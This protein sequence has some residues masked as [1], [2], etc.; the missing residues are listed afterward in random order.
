[1]KVVINNKYG[2]FSLSPEGVMR[3][4]EI[5]GITLYPEADEKWKSLNIVTYWKCPP[6][7][8]P[9]VLKDSD[10]YVASLD[11]RKASNLAY[12]EATLDDRGIERD[13]PAL[14]QVVEE[15][16]AAA[17]GRH[18]SLK[19]VEIPDDVKWQIEQY[20]GLEWVAEVHRT[21]N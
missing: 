10:F 14:V 17:D 4:A 6:D 8:R 15:M 19:I 12:N 1:M 5:K 11:E 9:K 20:D 13:D 21:W 16:G 3:Y 2:G 7:R 18:A